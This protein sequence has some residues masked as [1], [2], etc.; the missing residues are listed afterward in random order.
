MNEKKKVTIYDLAEALD[1]SVGTIYR[2]LHNT[3]RISAATKE[4]ILQ[5]AKEMN[6]TANVSAQS[7]RR[8]PI[9]I[10]VIFIGPIIQYGNEI[11]NGMKKAFDELA[12]SNIFSDIRTIPEAVSSSNIAMISDMIQ[13]FKD[14]QYKAVLLAPSGEVELLN[15]IIRSFSEE[16]LVFASVS[17]DIPN[18]ECIFSVIP[19]GVCAGKLAAELLYLCSAGKNITILTEKENMPMHHEYISG[20]MEFAQGNKFHSISIY[21]NEGNINRF[22]STINNVIEHANDGDGIYITSAISIYTG[23]LNRELLENK[24]IKIVTTDLFEENRKLIESQLI[25]ATIYQ[26]PFLCGYQSIHSMQDY[27]FKQTEPR[28]IRITPHIV[29]KSN[30]DLFPEIFNS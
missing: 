11:Q 3:G 9:H 26:N 16:G 6:Y 29:V 23:L 10:G 25:C 7:L 27:L 28:D 13:E 19:N 24:K 22:I 14:K 20:F 12:E 15:P 18:S 5:K 4:R 8:N 2:A 1:V 17:S 21:E 30:M